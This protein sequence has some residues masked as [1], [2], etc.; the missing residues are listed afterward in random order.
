MTPLPVIEPLPV[1]EN[2][3]FAQRL[4]GPL[5]AAE[6]ITTL[7]LNVGL[8]CNLAC[9]HCHVESSPKRTGA[10]ENLSA[11]TAERVLDWLAGAPDI[12]TV[13]LASGMEGLKNRLEILLGKAPEAPVDESVRQTVEKEATELTRRKEKVAA[14]GG[15]L[16]SAAFG[17]LNEVLP[18]GAPT[19]AAGD[20]Q[21]EIAATVRESLAQCLETGEDGKTRLTV[22]LPDSSALNGLADVLGRLGAGLK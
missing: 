2:P 21:K 11:E 1:G 3:P 18:G 20:R 17:F 14:A 7:Q 9:R 8:A 16:L 10:D 6:K 12:E 4:G 19:P 5:L 13:D 22:T 15:E